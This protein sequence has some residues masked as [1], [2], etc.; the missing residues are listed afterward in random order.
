MS[1]DDF[2]GLIAEDLGMGIEELLEEATFDSV[3]PG[4]C[5]SCR[6][7]TDSC[8]PDAS[9]NYCDCCGENRVKSA[10]VLAGLV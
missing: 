4:I 5:T 1:A 3:A 6:A 7:V 10:L 9:R 8:E 2:L